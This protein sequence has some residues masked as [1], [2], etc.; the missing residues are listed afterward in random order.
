MKKKEKKTLLELLGDGEIESA[1][2]YIESCTGDYYN[3]R[4]TAKERNKRW[5]LN[6][7][8][9]LAVLDMQVGDSVIVK[10]ED[11]P[12]GTVSCVATYAYPERK[13]KLLKVSDTAYMVARVK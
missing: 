9:V 4:E 12:R 8:E 5:A 3:N 13:Y 10:N 7:T 1:I 2:K 6:N 11:T